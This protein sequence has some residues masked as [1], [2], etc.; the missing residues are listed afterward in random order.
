VPE[1]TGLWSIIKPT[2]WT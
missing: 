2:R 1:I